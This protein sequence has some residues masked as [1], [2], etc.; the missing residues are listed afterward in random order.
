MKLSLTSAVANVLVGN[1][2]SEHKIPALRETKL[3][4]SLTPNRLLI[5]C[6]IGSVSSEKL[7]T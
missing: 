6:V 2:A 1:E 4:T 7:T 3:L 5:C